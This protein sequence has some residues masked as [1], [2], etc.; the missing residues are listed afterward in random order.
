MA[1]LGFGLV[2]ASYYFSLQGWVLL[3]GYDITP[4]QMWSPIWPPGAG[5]TT[6]TGEKKTGTSGEK[7]ATDPT[8]GVAE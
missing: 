2:F 8:S 1:A 4:A 6:G 3:K 5:S 7:S